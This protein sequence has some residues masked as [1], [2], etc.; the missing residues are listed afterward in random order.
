VS[1]DG[2]G[3]VTV[4]IEETADEDGYE[5]VNTFRDEDSFDAV[6]GFTSGQLEGRRMSRTYSRCK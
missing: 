3:V 5:Y 4:H 2:S 1:A 6:E